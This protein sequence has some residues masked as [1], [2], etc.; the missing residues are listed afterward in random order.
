MDGRADP[1]ADESATLRYNAYNRR[2]DILQALLADGRADPAARHSEALT[3]AACR[4]HLDI[5]QAFVADGR[6]SPVGVLALG[7]PEGIRR[8][9]ARLQRWQRR[10]TCL[11]AGDVEPAS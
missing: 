10:R 11:R 8:T 5:V 7:A 3:T 4:G 6:A 9:I 2:V 1:A